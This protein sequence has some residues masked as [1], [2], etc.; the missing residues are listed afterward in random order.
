[1]LFIYKDNNLSEGEGAIWVKSKIID[2]YLK[3]DKS[4]LDGT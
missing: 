3:K 1:M 4:R 2:N